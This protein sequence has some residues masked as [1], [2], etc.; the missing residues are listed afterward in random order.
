VW[1]KANEGT[2]KLTT[3]QLSMLL[4]G[5]DYRMLAWTAPPDV[6]V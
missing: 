4:E 5:I 3:A 2:V 6:A 1:P